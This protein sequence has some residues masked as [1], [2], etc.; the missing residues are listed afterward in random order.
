MYMILFFVAGIGNL[1]VFISLFRSRHRKSRISLMIRHLAVADLIV[2]FVMIPIEV[3]WRLTGRWLAG[4]VACKMVQ[5]VRALGPYLSSNVLVCI[6]LDRYF[7]VMHPL[8]VNAARK[9]GKMMLMVAW[10]ASLTY[11]VPQCFVFHLRSHPLNPD[12]KQCVTF[13]S[14]PNE[15]L[16][17]IYNLSCLVFLYF[18]PLTVIIVSY[19]CI[20]AE[21]S[22]TSKAHRVNNSKESIK[23]SSNKLRLRRSD[24]KT[25]ERARSRTLRMTVII[26]VIYILCCTPYTVMTLWYMF[27][28]T[29]AE[30]SLPVLV[31]DFFFM[32]VI[33]NSCMNPIVYGSFV[34]DFKKFSCQCSECGEKTSTDSMIPLNSGMV[35]KIPNIPI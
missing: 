33:S 18:I 23:N 16:E 27:D 7:A 12:Y 24:T 11:C 34:I 31:Q 35:K 20:L 4:N 14:F 13:G 5:F 32:M 3:C 30:Q 21:I 10:G 6:S 26:V 29:T 28:R 2:T 25:I 22:K 15:F 19:S 1:T 8:Q 17:L 9:R